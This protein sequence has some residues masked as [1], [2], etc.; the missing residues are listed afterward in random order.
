MG[1]DPARRRPQGR[2]G[3]LAPPT[4]RHAQ[5]R[6]RRG[7]SSSLC[8]PREFFGSI[9]RCL[10]VP[11]TEQVSLGCWLSQ[12]GRILA[13]TTLQLSCA[14]LVTGNQ[15]LTVKKDKG[16]SPEANISASC[17]AH[18]HLYTLVSPHAQYICKKS[19]LGP[20]QFLLNKKTFFL[21]TGLSWLFRWE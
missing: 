8:L 2:S 14:R 11:E 18:M 4:G 17:H 20:S 6:P 1:S 7:R 9:C 19:C 15:V 16:Q 12:Q 5:M 13:S 3:A 10:A 21:D